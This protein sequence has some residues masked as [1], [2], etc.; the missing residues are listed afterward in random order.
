M[1]PLFTRLYKDESGHL[2]RLEELYEK[3]YMAEM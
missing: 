2:A 3:I 1:A